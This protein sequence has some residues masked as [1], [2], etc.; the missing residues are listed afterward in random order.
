[1]IGGVMSPFTELPRYFLLHPA[2][3][4]FEYTRTV[5]AGY[6]P[7][8]V[9]TRLVQL[10]E[11]AQPAGVLLAEVRESQP[12]SWG[13]EGDDDALALGEGEFT[14]ELINV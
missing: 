5:D 1:M 6:S 2:A 7:A 3:F 14:T 12:G 10:L 8:A 4:G 9:R 11:A 13:F